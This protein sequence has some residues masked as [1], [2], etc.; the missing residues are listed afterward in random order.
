MDSP[1]FDT[2]RLTVRQWTVDD[3]AWYVDAIDAEILRFTREPEDLDVE[4]WSGSIAR[5]DQGGSTRTVAVVDHQ[6]RRVG[7]LGV[8]QHPDVVEL[9][10]WIEADSRNRGYATEILVGATSWAT[11][12]LGAK[13][14]ELQIHPDNA[15]S[16]TVAER[17]GFRFVGHRMSTD[18][19]AGSDGRIA[20]YRSVR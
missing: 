20:I 6:G 11:D 12:E 18:S 7:N 13:D 19:C 16:I 4:R 2:E 10:Y 3:A 1:Q 15:A 14:V 17:S 8:R 9:F 5:S